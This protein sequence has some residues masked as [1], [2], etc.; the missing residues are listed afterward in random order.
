MPD[1]TMAPRSQVMPQVTELDERWSTC[2][3]KLAAHL[4]VQGVRGPNHDDRGCWSLSFDCSSGSASDVLALLPGDYEDIAYRADVEIESGAWACDIE[5]AVFT[6]Y[7]H[8]QA[9][10]GGAVVLYP[11][12]ESYRAAS[13]LASRDDAAES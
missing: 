10:L 12:E 1:P 4:G 3:A 2:F 9:G 11:D 5:R 8:W 6:Y 13:E 7:D